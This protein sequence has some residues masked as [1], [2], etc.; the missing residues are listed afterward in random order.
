MKR[1]TNGLAKRGLLGLVAAAVL[2][3]VAAGVR[4]TLNDRAGILERLCS[5]HGSVR[6]G[7]LMAMPGQTGYQMAVLRGT[8]A[9]F[10]WRCLVCI[11][12]RL[13]C[14]RKGPQLAPAGGEVFEGLL[15][16]AHLGDCWHMMAIVVLPRKRQL[17]AE[18][19]GM[20]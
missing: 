15:G 8:I 7:R 20:G 9:F 19:A 6:E 11:L 18:A 12:R 14:P 2:L 10:F 17:V 5:L 4:F 16:A 13:P 3:A 1:L